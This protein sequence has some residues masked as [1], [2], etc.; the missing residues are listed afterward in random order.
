MSVVGKVLW[1]I[2]IYVD[3]LLVLVDIVVVVGLL[4]FYLLCLFQ[5]CIGIL[6]M[7]YLC[8][9]CL[10]VVVQQLVNGVGDILQVVLGVGYIIYVV[11]M[12]VFSEQ[13]GQML[14]CV[15]EQGIDG[16]VLVQVICVDEVLFVCIEVFCL[17]E[18]FVFQVVG[19][20]MWYIC[21]SG[22]VI[23]GQW[24]QFNCEW[25]MLVLISF[26][27]CCNSDD[28]GGFDYIVVLLVSMVLSVFVYW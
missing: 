25:L 16:L 28:K 18:I 5:V 15:C 10:I 13:F 2:E 27:V 14:E 24:V 12:C 20:G 21:D 6:V 1:Y 3:Q 26:G 17:F 19:I 11:F 23:F 4:L 7:C 22:G 8:G 9:C